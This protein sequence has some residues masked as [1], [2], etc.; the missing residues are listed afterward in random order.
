MPE[1]ETNDITQQV[2]E[3]SPA[4]TT[5]TTAPSSDDL[6]AA[7][8]GS[9]STK[10]EPKK[11][12]AAEAKQDDAENLFDGKVK[13]DAKEEA[14]T[15]SEAPEKYEFKAP[16]GMELDAEMA[17]EF[18]PI[19]KELGLSN[20]KAQKL[21]DY[22]ASNVLTKIAARQATQLKNLQ[23][24]WAKEAKAD[25]EFGGNEANLKSNMALVARAKAY[26]GDAFSKEINTLG[27]GNN[28]TL[29]KFLAKVGKGLAEDAPAVG[30]VAAGSPEP[31]AI[32]YPNQMKG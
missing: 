11:E 14:A 9:E 4:A 27:I 17:E 24:N 29:L 21:V 10:T 18:S 16:D 6:F 12:D 30:G 1:L 3:T 22:Y 26:A 25:P 8:A 31:K 32:L 19:A 13:E 23:G 20:E 28:P 7:A 2:T 5:A 15:D